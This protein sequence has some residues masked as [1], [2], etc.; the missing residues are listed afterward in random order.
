MI[1]SKNL[2]SEQYKQK[3]AKHI[4]E[5]EN[6][7]GAELVLAVATESGRYDRAESIWGVFIGMIMLS[8]QTPLEEWILKYFWTGLMVKLIAQSLLFV[9][10]FIFGSLVASYCHPLRGLFISNQEKED[11]LTRTSYALLG[12]AKKQTSRAIL[13]VYVS[14]F[15]RKVIVL[16][17]DALMSLLVDSELAMI[18]DCILESFARKKYYSGLKDC[19]L[20]A[21]EILSKKF[22]DKEDEQG[23]KLS[24]HVRFF[25]PR[26]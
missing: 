23:Q 7:T 2:T 21:G 4:Q 3:L 22:P 6:N 9:A 8:F 10:G 25:H 12:Q 16:G 17:D 11:E 13:L 5:I 1:N 18:R 24:N 14:L 15:E 19:I 26:P 20:K